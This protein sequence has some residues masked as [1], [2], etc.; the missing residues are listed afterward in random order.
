MTNTTIS[1]D[2]QVAV[3][4]GAGGGLGRSHALEL[5]RRG[6]SVV[7]N[8]VMRMPGPSGPGADAVVKEIEEA[9]GKAV[10]SD[11]SIATVDGAAGVIDLA[12]DHFGSID[13][14]VHNAGNWR[15]VPIEEMTADNLDPVL[16]VH[17]RGAFFLVRP[18]WKAMLENGYGRIVLT[19]SG[20]GAFG[21]VKGANYVA[22]KAG[23]LGLGRALGL[24]G[25]EVGIKAN[26]ILPLAVTP[27]NSTYLANAA[28]QEP[29]R[30]SPLV[31]YL[32]S[33]EC[34]VSGEAFSV[35]LGG[36]VAR[37][38]IA[39]TSGWWTG[40]P[41]PTAEDIAGHLAEIEDR[42]SYSVP[43]SVIEQMQSI[44]GGVSGEIV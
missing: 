41:F 35:G 9:G 13:V 30:V 11:H 16:D 24:E 34:A 23:L 10:A 42:S 5:S 43:E 19:S 36:H 15:N 14:V 18:A 27:T 7:V 26:C 4:T 44:S 17:L 33:R 8:D 38:F 6:A 28:R 37:V 21:R 25:S 31:A 20:A 39:V 29:E 2:G 3:V 1:L 22:A 32:A 40:D 12:L